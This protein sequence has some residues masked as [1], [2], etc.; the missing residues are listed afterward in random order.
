M[1]GLFFT[2]SEKGTTRKSLE[3]L[4]KEALQSFEKSF[5]IEYAHNST[6]I[7]LAAW[8]HAEFVKI[9]PFV[10]G[11]K[12]LCSFLRNII[13][14][15][16]KYRRDKTQ[17]SYVIAIDSS[18]GTGKTYFTDMFGKYLSG[19][20]GSGIENENKDYVVIR[21]DAWKNDFWN[22]AFEPFVTT[23]LENDMFYVDIEQ[24]SY[25]IK[26]VCGQEMDATGYLCRL[27][28]INISL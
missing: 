11:K 1:Y 5:D 22:N 4:P 16:D 12:R 2:L 14:N 18:W 3:Q 17:E 7:E 19:L 27:F 23:V 24:L 8:T 26:T 6:A 21:F 25:S 10:D 15:S 20:D 9:H 28:C 13:D